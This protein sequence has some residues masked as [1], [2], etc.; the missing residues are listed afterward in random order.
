[1]TPLTSLR[2][3][4]ADPNL[5]G[6]ALSGDSWLAWRA[7]LIAAMGEPLTDAERVAFQRFTGRDREPLRRVEEFAAVVGRRG[8]KSRAQATL[9][10]YLA[11]LCDYADVLVPG[12][13]G[14]LL[15]IAPDQR[16]AAITLNY[17]AATLDGSP[18]LR[19]LIANRTADTL[20]LTHGI[21]VEVRAASFRRLRGPTYVAC[22]ADEAAF[23][24]S[25]EF[26]ANADVEIVN[27]VRPGLATTGGP[28]IIASSPYARRGVLWDLYRHYY[29]SA[30]DPLVLVA[31][32]ASRDF[33]PTLPQ[34][35]VDR[36]LERDAASA[37]AE[38]GAQFRT[39]LE[40]FVAREV[41]EACVA[42]GVYE[43]PYQGK[44][45]YCGFV[46][47]S[48]GSADSFTLAIA[49]REG[50]SCVLDCVREVRPPFSPEAVTA[51]FVAVL[52]NY[53]VSKV[54]GDRYAGEYPREQFRKHS[55]TY[56]P[57]PK[58]KSDLYRDLLPLVNSRRLE[59]LDHPR[60]IAQLVGLERRTAR[61]G[62][63][64]IDHAPNAHD[65]VANACAGALLAAFNVHKQRVFLGS[66]GYGGGR[67]TWRDGAT[68]E[69]IDPKTL[70]P[71]RRT[72]IRVVRIPEALAPAVRGKC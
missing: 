36:A 48:G 65:D 69:E 45:R 63:D 6:T 10:C 61:S 68:G 26:S 16:Q 19:Q 72:N 13:R 49:H 18:M 27:A 44:F 38:Y 30:G 66:Y 5:L 25:D 46:D 54:C 28:L 24:Y 3:A 1:M 34:S 58:P 14:V 22:I 41:V 43:R 35:V 40:A 11:A 17:A 70:E 42:D 7:L 71:V 56:E 8:G 52:R 12:E 21:D 64:S 55:I 57:S 59:L 33:N 60:L 4:L 32:G 9:A 53:R 50:N 67:I 23:W 39:D 47:P 15:C 37:A 29:G 31:Q 20:S 2:N 51:E 62:K